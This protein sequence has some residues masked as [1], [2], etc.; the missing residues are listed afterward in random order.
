MEIIPIDSWRSFNLQI[1]GH[2]I[3]I[4]SMQLLLLN[5]GWHAAI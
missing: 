2:Q 5:N 3:T 4:S 1:G